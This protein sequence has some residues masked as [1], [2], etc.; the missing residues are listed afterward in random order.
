MI[1]RQTDYNYEKEIT[2]YIIKRNKELKTN[3]A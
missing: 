2:K 3:A 1:N